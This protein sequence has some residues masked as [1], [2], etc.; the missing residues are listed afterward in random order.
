MVDLKS[1]FSKEKGQEQEYYWSLVVEPGWVQAGA[2]TILDGKAKVV[3]ISPASAWETDEE[4]ISGADTA[5]SACVQDFPEDA[6]DPS[7][8]VFGVASTWVKDGQIEQQYLEKLKKV[9]SDLSL[10]PT[11]FVSLPE[12]V[13]HYT[14]SEEGSP[15]SGVVIGVARENLEISVFKL[16]NLVGTSYVA[17]SVSPVEDVIEGLTRFGGED[18]LPSRFILYDGKE[19]ELEEIK[20]SLLKGQWDEVE[21]IKFLHTPKVEVFTPETKVMAVALGGAAEIANVSAVS[22]SGDEE[23]VEQEVQ[24]TEDV[25][26]VVATDEKE[27]TAEEVGFVIGEDIKEKKHDEELEAKQTPPSPAISPQP[28][29]EETQNKESGF[30]KNPISDMVRNLRLS[31]ASFMNSGGF[32][33]I[34]RMR[35][36]KTYLIG[37][38][39]F[40][41]FLLLGFVA[42]WF[43]P[44]ATV[45]VYV[46]PKKLDEKVTIFVDPDSES[47]DLEEK[48]L[49][50][51][52][53]STKESGERT[54]ST[55]GTRE[56]GDKAT[57]EVTIYRVGSELTIPSGTVLNGPN[58]IDFT[59]NED[60]TVASGS[61]SSPGTQK[62][63]VTAE[64]IGA[65]Y[66]LDSGNTFSVGNYGDSVDAKN[67]AAFSGG[68]SRT[69]SAVSDDDQEALLDDLTEE[70]QD[71]AEGSLKSKIS[72][73]Q[74][75]LDGSVTSDV[76]EQDFSAKVGD[77][78]DSLKLNLT[79]DV[80]AVAVDKKALFDLAKEILKDRIPQGYVLR[81]SQIDMQFDLKDED[82]G[83]YELEA[84]IDANLLPEIKTD[85][86][87]QKITG[88]L[89]RLAENY[90]NT[91]PGF[92]RAEINISPRL[93]GRLG[94]LPRSAKNINVEVAAER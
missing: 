22:K 64:D 20:Q 28:A 67:E 29:F 76:S 19:S 43:L 66:N 87:A 27:V 15:L 34:F 6:N 88:K 3:A 75:Y 48:I 63:A 60:V 26:N 69:I 47:V 21:K 13:A 52:V 70:L 9:C 38:I 36:Q 8:T 33:K 51:E 89:P 79:L 1:L 42:W 84:S 11:G 23:D 31:F 68:S 7:K 37:G 53:L 30:K 78:A 5:L 93:P 14:K 90:L 24:V 58:D 81:E 62:A 4:L 72:D 18:V 85:E 54:S 56:V 55:T 25:E 86:V 16:G 57:G 80:N 71:K 61:A 2:W 12:S 39:I 92:T 41:V 82:G 40:V 73:N 59:L 65:Q 77:E 32:Q 45:T 10:E 50:G 35:G 44:K 91:I 46:S 83:V 17:R 49:P 94:T 74:Y